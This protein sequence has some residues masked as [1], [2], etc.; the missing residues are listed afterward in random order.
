MLIKWRHTAKKNVFFKLQPCV[1]LL[2]RL[3]HYLFIY[4]FIYILD[5]G[6][7]WCK[8]L[9]LQI[10]LRQA[11]QSMRIPPHVRGF[12]WCAAESCTGPNPDRPAPEPQTHASGQ[13]LLSPQPDPN[14]SNA[15][16]HRDLISHWLNVGQPLATVTVPVG[17][18]GFTWTKQL[19]RWELHVN[20]PC[21]SAT[22]V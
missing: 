22:S 15:T 16:R 4:L 11:L 13:L 2:W 12:V 9:Q 14:R 21:S 1:F 6:C 17:R 8:C 20:P 7:F 5:T 19:C 10:P 18:L 3:G